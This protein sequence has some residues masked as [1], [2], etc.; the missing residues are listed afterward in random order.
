V[1]R[2]GKLWISLRT[3]AQ[4]HPLS[5]LGTRIRKRFKSPLQKIAAAHPEIAIDGVETIVPYVLA[6][7]NARLHAV[8]ATDADQ[9]KEMRDWPGSIRIW[10]SSSARKGMVGMGGVM[11]NGRGTGVNGHHCTYSCTLGPDTAQNPYVAELVAIAEGLARLR[12]MLRNREIR[13]FTRNR[14]AVQAVI[15]P[16]GQSGQRIISQIYKEVEGLT[17]RDNRVVLIAAPG[18]TECAM[19]QQAKAAA[20]A[21][22]EPGRVAAGNLQAAK[23]TMINMRKAAGKGMRSFTSDVGRFTRRL[24]TALPGPHTRAIYDSLGRKQANILAQLRTGMTRLNGYLHRIGAAE[25]D[26]CMCGHDKE[27]VEHF[28]FR[29]RQWETQRRELLEQTET[30]RGNLS[31]FLGGKTRADPPEWTPNLDAVKATIKYAISTGRLDAD[32]Q[33]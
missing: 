18:T 4:T 32:P 31:F 15:Q 1:E 11:D 26:Q 25:S 14:G 33:E 19:A 7:W 12:P 10:T 28:L 29:C 5:R 8:I 6:P 2:A 30:R 13:I 23:S 20:R 9:A 17:I 3:L 21:S 24:D 22:T 16:Q 27:T